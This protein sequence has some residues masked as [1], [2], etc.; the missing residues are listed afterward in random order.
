MRFALCALSILPYRKSSTQTEVQVI[1]LRNYFFAAILSCLFFTFLEGTYI[2]VYSGNANGAITF[3]GNAQGLDGAANPNNNT[4][5]GTS[6]DIGAFITTQNTQ[7]GSYPVGTTLTWQDNA[8]F[9]V[10]DLPPEST[11]LHAELIWSGSFASPTD[12]ITLADTFTP[13]TLITPDNVSHVIN[14]N[15]VTAQQAPFNLVTMY[16]RSADV[17][18]IVQSGGGGTYTAAGLPASVIGSSGADCAGWTL[19]VAYENPNMLTSNLNLY[20]ACERE[21]TPAAQI[22]GFTTPLAGPFT[23]RLFVSALEGDA[24]GMGDRLLVGPTNVLA[25][26]ANAISGVNNPINNFF[27]SQINTLAPLT[28][29]PTS[30]KWIY[31]GSSAL[32]DTRGSF[33]TANSDANTSTVVPGARQGYDITSIALGSQLT[34]GQNQLFVQGSSVS[35][36]FLI[37]SLG[38][39]I[40]VNSPI[41]VATKTA[42]IETVS[43]GSIVTY[44]VTFENMGQST[45]ESLVFTDALPPGMVFVANSFKIDNVLVPG[46]TGADL[47]TGISLG[48]LAVNDTIT[49][50]FQAQVTQAFGNYANS[51]TIDYLFTPFG[52]GSSELLATSTNTQVTSSFLVVNDT[53]TTK[54]NHVLVETTSVFANDVGFGLHF[55]PYEPIHRTV[56]G[57]FVQLNQDGTYVYT[58]PKDFSGIDYF[59]Y[60]VADQ[61]GQTGSATVTI[62][63]TPYSVHDK[64]S[65]YA[66]EI[67]HTDK[68]VLRNDAGSN[69]KIATYQHFTRA[70]G[71]VNMSEDGTYTYFPPKDFSGWDHFAYEAEDDAGNGTTSIVY[72]KVKP[73]ACRLTCKTS[74]NKCLDGPSLLKHSVG[75]HL[76]I[77][78]DSFKSRRG[79]KVTIHKDGTFSYC[80]PRHKKGEDS[81]KFTICDKAGNEAH[82]K[83]IITID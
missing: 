46:I 55:S 19:A 59:H 26:P 31:A 49:V 16:V 73:V 36:N 65:T 70:G 72:I 33:G 24:G 68:S 71:K 34:N 45:A 7:V 32:L 79:G 25:Y 62:Y 29:D 40:Q 15:P 67:L 20:V 51:A 4:L 78:H 77:E 9:A 60:S 35:E 43:L 37:N 48:D 76:K 61:F 17:T 82:G 2:Q 81:F 38:I 69:L 6:G 11:V 53:A 13:I 64:N 18:S 8:S 41:I 44:T 57:G 54:A 39:Q 74:C 56:Q 12:P 58:P 80:P 50:E 42:D 1:S 63:V 23:S 47:I 14:Y 3:T 75:S 27:A 66:N 28:T 52:S 83:V 21:N 5:P 30:G 22:T 10:L